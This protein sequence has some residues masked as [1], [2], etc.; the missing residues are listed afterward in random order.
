MAWT[1]RQRSVAAMAARW[2]AQRQG[3]DVDT[4]RE[5]ILRQLDHRAMHDGRITSTSPKL[6]NADYEFYMSV[7]ER[8]T[9]GRLQSWLPGYWQAKVD[10]HLQRMR[11]FVWIK[12]QE[13]YESGRVR[14][15]PDG[16][17]G[18]LA[19]FLRS[20]VTGGRT[21]R[22]DDCNWHELRICIQAFERI[23]AGSPCAV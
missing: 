4:L 9:G 20:R 2:V 23:N 1:S 15:H 14:P 13:L 17:G 11:R 5:M 16:P 10:D 19:G 21:D 18:F 12:A 22:L 6:T 8:T 7:L 3:Q